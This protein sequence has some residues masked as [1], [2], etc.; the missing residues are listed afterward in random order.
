MV[1]GNCSREPSCDDPSGVNSCNDNCDRMTEAC[2]CM[3]GFLMKDGKCVLPSEC[4]CFLTQIDL[5]LLVCN[6]LN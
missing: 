2:V 4:G 1:F 5:V 6:N 3:N